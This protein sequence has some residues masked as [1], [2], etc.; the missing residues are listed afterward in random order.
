MTEGR[1]SLCGR[2]AISAKRI[3]FRSNNFY[4]FF[5]FEKRENDG[6]ININKQNKPP[7]CPIHSLFGL[8]TSTH[9][10]KNNTKRDWKKKKRKGKNEKEKEKEIFNYPA[11]RLIQ[12]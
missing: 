4:S 6:F 3:S 12:N 1:G 8:T 9:T 10:N 2:C 5:F 7:N 11:F